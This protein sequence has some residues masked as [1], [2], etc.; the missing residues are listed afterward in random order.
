[1][2]SRWL[3]TPEDRART[4][5]VNT[6]FVEGKVALRQVFPGVVLLSPA[7][8]IPP[9]ILIHT[10]IVWGSGSKTRSPVPKLVREK[11]KVVH[12]NCA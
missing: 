2:A 9:L 8:I 11:E 5:S 1:M 6:G 3:L 7:N 10:R 4:C 12:M